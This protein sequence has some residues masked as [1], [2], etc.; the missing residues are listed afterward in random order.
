M[1]KKRIVGILASATLLA[2]LLA[3][4]SED[5]T[6]KATTETKPKETTKETLKP[7]DGATLIIWD[8]GA[9]EGAWAT[10]VAE[11]FTKKYN[12]PVEVQEVGHTDAAGK[13][14]T[15]GPAGLGADVFN[16][17]HDH[18]GKL[19][20]A[21]LV[22]DNYYADD[23]Q[24][25]FL[26]AAVNGTSFVDKDGKKKMFGYP[27]SIET[28]ALYYNKD[29]VKEAPKTWDDLFKTAKGFQATS[30]GKNQK[31]GFMMEPGN[32]YYTHAF[33]SGYGGYVFGKEDTDPTDLGVNNEGAIKSAEF[34]KKI[35]KELLPMKKEDITG[36]V[37]SSF[38]NESKLAYRISGPWDVKNHQDA[39]VN[40][41]IAPLPTLDNGETP[42]SY[43]GIKA[44]YVNSYSKYPKAA[45]LLAQM[46]SSEEMLLKRYEMTGQLPPAT[47]LLENETIKKDEV[48][49]AFLEQA[50]NAVPMPNIPEMQAVWGPMETAYT[51]IWN[52]GTD[53]KKTFDAAK[54]QIEDAVATQNKK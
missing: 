27:I 22:Y 44:Y 24:D 13:L 10:Y 15:D 47:S 16:S 20:K 49:M 34:M 12:V 31:Y 29:I 41:G 18:L 9:D 1:I 19:V 28:Y 21:G 43:S 37:I 50:K 32:F 35:N 11:Q 38:F 25:M 54:E 4:C 40:F 46:A 33:L 39:G 2:G 26:E 36:D 3:G 52:D 6:K 30:K 5:E 8:N 48:S 14:E 17:A 53:S 42:K 51:S 7:E 45:T 23:Y